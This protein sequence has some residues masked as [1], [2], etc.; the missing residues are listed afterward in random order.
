MEKNEKTKKIVILSV[1]IFLVLMLAGVLL[2]GVLKDRDRQTEEKTKSLVQKEQTEGA[3]E[4]DDTEETEPEGAS[5]TDKNLQPESGEE[6]ADTRENET[7]VNSEKENQSETQSATKATVQSVA[8]GD[9]ENTAKQPSAG[10]TATGSSSLAAGNGSSATTGSS[11]SGVQGTEATTGKQPETESSTE[12]QPEQEAVASVFEHPGIL[13]S[14]ESFAYMKYAVNQ[15][16]SPNVDTWNVLLSTGFSDAGWWPRPV[17]TVIRGGDG[18]NVSK[19]YIDVAR[20]YQCALIWKISGNEAH[21]KAACRI[22]NGWSSTLKTVSGNADRYLAAGLF[23]YQLANVSEIMRDHPDFKLEQMQ[24]M[25]LNV[26][27]YPLNERFLVGNEYGYSHNDAYFQNYWANW[28]LCNMASAMAIGI[29][30]DKEEIYNL[31]VDYY[32]NGIGNGSIYNAIPY[33]YE[34]GT[35]Q[36][37]ESGRDQG[38]TNLGIGLMAC[39]CEM[40]WNQGD[41]L[42]GWADNRFLKAAEYVAKYN[43]G[44]DVQFSEYEWGSGKNGTVNYHTVISASGRGEVRPIWSMIYNHYVNRK[45]LEAPNIKERLEQLG[46]YEYG[47][48]GHATT[49]DQPGW[50]TLTFAGNIGKNNATLLAGSV[51]A[52]KYRIVSA[53]TGKSLTVV[54]GKYVRQ[55]VKGSDAGDVWEIIDLG[56]G[57]YKIK[58]VKNGL[59]MEVDAASNANG[60]LIVAGKDTGKANQRFAFLTGDVDN[61]RIIASNSGKALDI[62]WGTSDES[63]NI[64]QWRYTILNFQKWYLEKVE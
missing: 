27:Y 1:V 18:D 34:D 59:V 7:T 31:A 40:A 36:W 25:L 37:Q 39:V 58:N 42:Y 32:M 50:G 9:E 16:I 15:S 41:D 20:A 64:Q 4:R 63:V 6:S 19:L 49:F 26:F 60:A 38:H 62:P 46:G 21:G 2:A 5:V 55:C 35:A 13:H 24:T 51:K 45:G 23:G 52:G 44:Y 53:H 22:L 11:S 61:Y 29:F 10:S 30:C 17:E 14:A 48:G 57:E 8:Q 43:N 12:K 3:S 47:A 28:D 33:V 56:G 54:E